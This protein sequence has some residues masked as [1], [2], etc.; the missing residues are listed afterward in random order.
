[1]SKARSYR[2][3]GWALAVSLLLAGFGSI[4]LTLVPLRF[5]NPDWEVGTFGELAATMG[6][7]VMGLTAVLAMGLYDRRRAVLLAVAFVSL[8]VGVFGLL[9]VGLLATDAPVAL[10]AAKFASDASQAR[11]IKIVLLKSVIL[12]GLFS[13]G[14]LAVG[15]GAIRSFQRS[16]S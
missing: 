2:T 14:T 9:S 15:W 11:S 13:V 4:A 7:P 12:L 5:G 6:L 1:V 16:R 10:D 8:V 3:V